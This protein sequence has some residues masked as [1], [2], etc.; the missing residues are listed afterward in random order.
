VQD[1]LR[2]ESGRKSK[3]KKLKKKNK[4]NVGSDSCG[5]ALNIYET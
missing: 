1:V 3:R 2:G 4:V 5:K